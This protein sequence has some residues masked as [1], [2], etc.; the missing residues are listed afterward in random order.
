MPRTCRVCGMTPLSS[1][2]AGGPFARAARHG[3]VRSAPEGRCSGSRRGVGCRAQTRVW[4]ALLDVRSSRLP[5]LSLPDESEASA[6]PSLPFPPRCLPPPPL[7]PVTLTKNSPLYTLARCCLPPPPIPSLHL[8]STPSLPCHLDEEL[9]LVHLGQVLPQVLG[10]DAGS[11][12]DV[13]RTLHAPAQRRRA[14]RHRHRHHTTWLRRRHLLLGQACVCSAAGCPNNGV[15]LL[16]PPPPAQPK[17]TRAHRITLMRCAST[18]C[19]QPTQPKTR[20][21]H[22]LMLIRC[23]VKETLTGLPAASDRPCSTSG[24]WRC[25]P[26]LQSATCTGVPR[27]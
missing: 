9:A 10:L 11:K 15:A 23:G 21:T 1:T 6:A 2:C 22:R 14:R 27:P 3:Q 25:L 20:R 17:A 16:L 26:T 8:S 5:C 19:P 18:A 4:T 13:R 24:M 12:L 7:P